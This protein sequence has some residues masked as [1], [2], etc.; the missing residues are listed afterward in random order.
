MKRLPAQLTALA[1]AMS[2]AAL[3]LAACGNTSSSDADANE[4]APASSQSAEVDPSSW[5]T[6]ADA[7]ATADLDNLNYGYNEDCF[8]CIS[9]HGESYVRTVA[10]M[11]DETYDKLCNLD[12][13]A[14]DYNEQFAAIA[15]ELELIEAKDVTSELI[16]QED[17]E[18]Y[19]GKTGQELA[20]DG[21]AFS[22]YFMYG[23][24]QTGAEL[25]KDSFS[26]MFTFD[27]QIS[28]D[29]T[30]DGGAAIM[31]ATIVEAESIG[32]LSNA[33]LDPTLVN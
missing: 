32:N 19:V 22:S 23:G 31:D 33:A 15:G 20:D 1:L 4:S 29:Q 7:F 13:G 3:P 2:L 28:E 26:Y 16:S 10:Q 21:F 27:T 25:E 24:E 6:L 12:M 30:E 17:I 5:T 14:E 8:V 11:T 9:V 18:Q